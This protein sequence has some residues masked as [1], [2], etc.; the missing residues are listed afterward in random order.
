MP[1]SSIKDT[2]FLTLQAEPEVAGAHTRD[3]GGPDGSS[4]DHA[5]VD[6][7]LT[8]TPGLGGA[9]SPEPSTEASPSADYGRG[10][11]TTVKWADTVLCMEDNIAYNTLSEVFAGMLPASRIG[12]C[13]CP[14]SD[15]VTEANFS[16]AAAV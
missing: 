14:S 1:H 13:W 8:A 11:M 6:T 5:R 16:T 7:L 4:L 12:R 10:S 15:R 3:G 2:T 9:R